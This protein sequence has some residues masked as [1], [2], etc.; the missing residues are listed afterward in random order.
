MLSV[1]FSLAVTTCQTI[2][3]NAPTTATGAKQ[4]DPDGSGTTFDV[5][6]DY[7]S[8]P[9]VTQVAKS[10]SSDGVAGEFLR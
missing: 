2:K 10:P 7:S 4:I 5:T 1:F 8:Y 9:A 3:D 6:C